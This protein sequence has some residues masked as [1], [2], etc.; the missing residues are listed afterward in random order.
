M[1]RT[2]ES[3]YWSKADIKQNQGVLAPE[4]RIYGTPP[5][6]PWAFWLLLWPISVLG[7]EDF[8]G[9]LRK[10]ASKEEIKKEDLVIFLVMSTYKWLV[11]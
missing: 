3:F 10:K 8:N 6:L 9:P 7:Q 4:R 11:H 5:E 2:G 1:R